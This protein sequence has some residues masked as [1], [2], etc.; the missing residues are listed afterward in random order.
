[1]S[2]RPRTRQVSIL[3]GVLVLSAAIAVPATASGA[4]TP[5]SAAPTSMTARTVF[6]AASHGWS[7]PDDLAAIGRE[8]YVSF[9]NGV[10]STGGTGGSPTQS[11]IVEFR[12]DGTIQHTWQLTGKCD[13]LT[14]DP[15]HHRLIATV[16]EDGNSSLYVIDV[17][18]AAPMHF[19][20]DADPLPHGGGTDA[21]TI[22][23]G[24]VYVVASAP[25]TGGPALYRVTLHDGIAHLAA[26]P[27]YDTSTATVANQPGAGAPAQLALTDPDS[28]T[29]VPHQAARFRGDFML[30]AQGDQQAVFAAHLGTDSQRLSV[31][32]LTQSVDDTAFA[33]GKGGVLVTTDS[34]ADS[35][36]AISGP[37]VRGAAYT[38][39]TP[40]NANNAPP[41]PAPN[42]LGVI[43]LETGVVSPV[44]TMGTAFR[45][46]ALIYVP[47]NS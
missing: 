43:D 9:Q 47:A 38:S 26:A 37:F 8:L 4:T 5:R 40:G 22:Q 1:M 33:T 19:V 23:N 32:N 41:N 24:K 3:L 2:I 6:S 15:Q 10:P 7:S 21:V 30:D 28:S 42:Y 13:G 20:Y 31:L 46:H 35:V 18:K 25:A 11:T 14:S 17:R 27:F 34:T 29:T 16:N 44:T 12:L 36:V 39:V 45:T